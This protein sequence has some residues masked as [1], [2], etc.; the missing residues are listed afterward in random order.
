MADFRVSS[1][2]AAT[3]SLVGAVG[4]PAAH[5]TA[6][7]VLSTTGSGTLV[8]VNSGA[9]THESGFAQ[10]ITSYTTNLDTGA[11]L[12]LDTQGYS[13]TAN[14][15]FDTTTTYTDTLNVA[16]LGRITLAG[17]HSYLLNAQITMSQFAGDATFTLRWVNSD[18]GAV[19]GSAQLVNGANSNTNSS[20]G[21][22]AYYSPSITSRVQAQITAGNNKLTRVYSTLMFVTQIT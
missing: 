16:S 1:L 22:V 11:H 10:Q 17:S 14:I 19:I 6:G 13:S 20:P 21:V 15:I 4:Y 2:S 12:K 8:F 18:T 9:G 5:G 7:Q 3:A